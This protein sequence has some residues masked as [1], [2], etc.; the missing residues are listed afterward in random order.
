MSDVEEAERVALAST[1]IQWERSTLKEFVVLVIGLVA[2][3]CAGWGLWGLWGLWIE[4]DWP[5]PLGVALTAAY[6][7]WLLKPTKADREAEREE[8]ELELIKAATRRLEQGGDIDEETLDVL[9]EHLGGR[10]G[11]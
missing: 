11:R 7:W 3:A 8:A 9:E 6:L 10:R 2:L 4:K 1:A 5:L